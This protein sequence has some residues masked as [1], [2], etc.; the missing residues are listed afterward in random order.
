MSHFQT[1]LRPKSAV[2][3]V[4]ISASGAAWL[5]R[6]SSQRLQLQTMAWVKEQTE[7]QAIDS[8][9]NRLSLSRTQKV[10]WVTA[11]SLLK[12]WLQQPPDN[13]QS[14]N[15]L[16]AVTRQRAQQ[17]FGA[18]HPSSTNGHG[19]S[20]VV[21]ADWHASQAFLCGAMPAS[22][23]A[24]LLGNGS[25][26]DAHAASN[27]ACSIVSPLQLILARFLK[28]F[29]A[30]GWLSVV[31]ANTLYLMFFKNKTCVHFRSLQLKPALSTADMQAIALVEWQRD[32]L[33]TQQNSEQLHWLCLMPIAAASHASSA[34]L[35]PV[36]WHPA[37]AADMRDAESKACLGNQA[38]VRVELSEVKLVAWCALQC[39]EKQP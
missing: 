32:M 10:L 13:I 11:P 19:S 28:Q 6:V 5:E 29:P 23:H 16:H 37:N 21:S 1:S 22:W 38:D 17:L 18:V 31:V 30:H 7:A 15:E 20:W 8:V 4:A 25:T 36:Q 9:L 3:T 33:R 27:K 14:L 34:L 12:H 2:Q 26:R 35:K 24:A 39:A